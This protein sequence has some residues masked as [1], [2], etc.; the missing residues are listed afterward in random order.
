MDLVKTFETHRKWKFILIGIFSRI[1]GT[2]DSDPRGPG[3]EPQ[4]QS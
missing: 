2:V 3:F 4:S 1:G